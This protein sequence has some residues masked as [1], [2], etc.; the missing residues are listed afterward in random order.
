MA[1]QYKR[2]SLNKA[3]GLAYSYHQA[4]SGWFRLPDGS[5]HQG[6]TCSRAVLRRLIAAT[7]SDYTPEAVARELEVLDI[8]EKLGRWHLINML[9]EESRALKLY[10]TKEEA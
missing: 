6:G 7:L 10:P 2:H 4:L 3:L 9:A 1:S 8:D 5:V